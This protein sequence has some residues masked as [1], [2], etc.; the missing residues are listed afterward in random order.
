MTIVIN[1]LLFKIIKDILKN[2]VSN[3]DNFTTLV[4]ENEEKVLKN[5]CHVIR[6]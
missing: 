4:K 1:F 6:L 5:E 3:I 2:R